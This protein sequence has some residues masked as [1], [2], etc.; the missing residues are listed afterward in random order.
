MISEFRK[1]LGY[2]QIKWHKPNFSGDEQ[3]KILFFNSLK[4]MN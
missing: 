2:L 3:A 4:R 1:C